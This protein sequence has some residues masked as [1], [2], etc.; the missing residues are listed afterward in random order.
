MPSVCSDGMVNVVGCSVT[1]L[2]ILGTKVEAGAIWQSQRWTRDDTFLCNMIA[3]KFDLY[4]YRR[5]TGISSSLR[6]LSLRYVYLI[7]QGDLG[8]P[9]GVWHL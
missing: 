4:C 1:V 2:E 7:Y 3:V 6:T 5:T 8:R 9:G